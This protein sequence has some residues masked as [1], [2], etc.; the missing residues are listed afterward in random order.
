[1]AKLIISGKYI[2]VEK[3][4]NDLFLNIFK[5]KKVAKIYDMDL[6]IKMVNNFNKNIEQ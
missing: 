3:R 2:R 6:A 4:P 5:G 1:M